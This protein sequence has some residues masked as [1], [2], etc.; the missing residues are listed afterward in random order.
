[1]HAGILIPVTAGGFDMASTSSLCVS[2]QHMKL[3]CKALSK[4]ISH[5]QQWV[6][7]EVISSFGHV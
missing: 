5:S 7:V 6:V 1:M 4:I 3:H 2:R